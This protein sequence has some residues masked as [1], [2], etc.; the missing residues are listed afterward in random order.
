VIIEP[1]VGRT[2][3]QEEIAT[4]CGV[5]IPLDAYRHELD[6]QALPRRP[7][8]NC[9]VWRASIWERLKSE[10]A[11]FPPNA[12]VYDGYWRGDDPIPALIQYSCG[13][14][15]AAIRR[16]RRGIHQANRFA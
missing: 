14:S 4:L 6:L 7:I 3:W 16:L 15:A 11:A 2:D 12:V 1:T 10:R 13:T 5:N 9:V 8:S